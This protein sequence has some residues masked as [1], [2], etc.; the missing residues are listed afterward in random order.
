M[1]KSL[2]TIIG[3]LRGS[4]WTLI[5]AGAGALSVV[6]VTITAFA[7]MF[8]A[9]ETIKVQAQDDI[10]EQG[11]TLSQPLLLSNSS[12][13][14]I[15]G[16]VLS[17]EIANIYPRRD[18][19]V[20][21]IYVDIGDT[22]QKNQIVALLLPKGVEG[23]SAAAIAEKQA[24]KSQ[25]EA[26]YISALAVADEAANNAQQKI[27]EK[28]IELL[29]AQNEQRS[30]IQKFD[31]HKSNVTQMLEQA[32]ISA[33]HAR[34]VIEHILIG[35]NSR[36]GADLEENDIIAKLGLL[37]SQTRYAIIPAILSLEQLEEEYLMFDDDYR[38]DLIHPLM[39]QANDALLKANELLVAT[40]TVPTVKP[41]Q[42]THDMLTSMTNQV[43]NAQNSAL[44]AKEKYEDAYNA[45]ETLI[46]GEPSLY[47]AWKSGSSNPNAQSNKVKTL[48]A[49]LTTAEQNLDFTVSKQNQLIAKTESMVGVADAML[50]AEYVQSGHRQIRSPFTGTVS[51]RFIEVGQI[52]MPSNASFELTDVPTSLAKISKREIQFGLPEHLQ[53]AVE[54]GDTVSFFIPDSDNDVFEAIVSRK[55]PQVDMQTHTVT[56]QAKL[57]DSLEF[58]HHTNV[59]VRIIDQ[60]LPLYRVPSYA[61]KREGDENILWILNEEVPEKVT[62]TVRS[63]DGEFAEVTGDITE[64]TQIILDPPD[65]II[66]YLTQ[67]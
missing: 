6:A 22:V 43:L 21:D 54:V 2:R 18:G 28:A 5:I 63:E 33:R 58:P 44:K 57:D 53:S 39:A 41:G 60:S 37:N 35:S 26:D 32:F 50:N 56:V 64:D 16:T 30:I 12:S 42:Y 49:Q 15:L 65:M 52:V 36:A 59:R 51:K 47:A 4:K 10:Q 31:Q 62:V 8:S 67:P 13:T 40:P 3:K 34:Q 7:I 61:V 1:K 23:Q 46:A 45:Y 9:A 55:S 29:V 20:E 48:T 14:I 27:D 19:I 66:N 11:L 25:A 17:H 38:K 24:R